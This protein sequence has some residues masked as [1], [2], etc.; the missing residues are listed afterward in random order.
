MSRVDA[1]ANLQRAQSSD[2]AVDIR[3]LELAYAG[4][5]VLRGIDLQ[6]ESN[7]F[8]ALL[9]ANGAGKTTLLKSL[10]GVVKPQ[11]GTVQVLGQ[12]AGVL[13]RQIGYVPQVRSFLASARITGMDFVASAING[14]RWG[15][16]W[17]PREARS[18]VVWALDKVQATELAKRSV[19]DMSGGERQRLMLAQA[20]LGRPRLMLLDEPLISLDIHHQSR[21]IRLV[22]SLQQELGITVLF[23]AHEINPLLDAA[24]QVLYLG[25][26]QAA[27]GSVDSVIQSN[28][29]TRLYATPVEV[30]RHG[31]RIFVM[32]GNNAAE[33]MDHHHDA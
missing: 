27:I 20:L 2:W 3:K 6:I 24:D 32:A 9:G 13:S 12:P 19:M 17:L 18:E 7:Q 23:S 14:D 28:V 22:K 1:G 33:N 10:M 26:G 5:S 30:V 8:V 21:V 29:L 16:P 4:R 15:W 31:G 11:A 25:N